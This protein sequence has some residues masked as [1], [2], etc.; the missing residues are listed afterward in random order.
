[1]SDTTFNLRSIARHDQAFE[2]AGFLAF[3][4]SFLAFARFSAFPFSSTI[5]AWHG[6]GVLAGL[7]LV[8]SIVLGGAVAFA[9][10]SLPAG[11]PWRL[12]A[13]ALSVLA[14]LFFVI[15]W[16]TLPSG[17]LFGHH[18]GYGLAWG[19]YVTL[20]LVLVQAGAGYLGMRA[21]GEPIM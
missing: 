2:G 17:N 18:Y 16:L 6:V 10:Q 12:I 13:T 19:G 14:L 3:V 4:F 9:P 11:A 1:M 7:L 8:A 21:A 20:I 15:R 5:S